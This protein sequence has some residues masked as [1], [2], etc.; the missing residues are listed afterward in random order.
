MLQITQ[1]HNFTT[2]ET[3]F[4][5][6]FYLNFS[7]KLKWSH[8]NCRAVSP[9][10]IYYNTSPVCI[11]ILFSIRWFSGFLKSLQEGKMELDM[12]KH[13]GTASGVFVVLM[14][15]SSER[16]HWKFVSSGFSCILHLLTEMI[17]CIIS[18]LTTFCVCLQ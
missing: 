18:L 6:T 13:S 12:R 17:I 8:C 2:K 5:F 7:V 3:F 14:A 10:F 9:Y 4:F 15:P 11:C 16:L 1:I